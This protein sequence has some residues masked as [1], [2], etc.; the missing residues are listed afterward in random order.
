MRGVGKPL[1]Y[2]SSSLLRYPVLSI[3]LWDPTFGYSQLD[4][5]I[6]LGK[7]NPIATGLAKGK[8]DAKNEAAYQALMAL[9]WPVGLIFVAVL[10]VGYY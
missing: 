2:V 3:T 9:K 5:L 10:H 4:V 6:V 7:G 8:Q 1:C